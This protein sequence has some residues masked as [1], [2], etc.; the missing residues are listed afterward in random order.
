MDLFDVAKDLHFGEV[1]IKHDPATGLQAI[2]AI[3]DLKL[4][5]AIG[6][7]RLFEYPDS[8]AAVHDALRLARGMSY[9]AA[10]SNLPH[11]GG[12]AVII[13]PANFDELDRRALFK[14]FGRFVD[15]LGGSYITCEDVGTRVEDMDA[16]RSET[17]QVLGFDP[18][19]GSSGDPSPFTAFGVRRGIE[20][21]AKFR[22]DRDDLQD[23]HV[24]IQGLGSVG[25]YLAQELHELG[26][27]LTVTD[28]DDAAIQRC[29]DEFDAEAVGPDEIFAVDCDVFAPCALGSPINDK[30]LPTLQCAV[31]AGA[32]N[33]QLAEKRH[34]VELREREIVYV[35]DYAINAGGLINVAQEFRG[36]DEQT[37]RRKTA[38]IYETIIEILERS[39]RE[40]LPTNLVANRVVEERLYG[41]PLQ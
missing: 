31:I 3:H 21:A 32:A 1:H 34:G 7:C 12:K 11:G 26:A 17:E 6:G 15:S 9:K 40:S 19:Q 37:A 23:L 16:V 25:Y 10:I 41:S 18:E 33:N 36:Y 22:W 5:P 28:I 27:Q 24:A 35:P 29:V 13:K 8:D 14:A 2:V 20:A 38:A 4:G 30:T 39:A